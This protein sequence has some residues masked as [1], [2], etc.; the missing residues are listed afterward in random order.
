MANNQSGKKVIQYFCDECNNIINLDQEDLYNYKK[1]FFHMDCL[2]KKLKRA[3]KPKFSSEDI[4]LALEQAKKAGDITRKNEKK[5]S[6]KKSA[7]VK[8]PSISSSKNKQLEQDKNLL[9]DYI[10]SKYRIISSGDVQK[11]KRTFTSINNGTY[12]KANGIKIPYEQLYKMFVHYEQ[13]L[14]Y[15]HSRLKSP[16]ESQIL[17]FFYD[18]SVIVNKY[19]EFNQKSSYSDKNENEIKTK[20]QFEVSNYLQGRALD[21]GD[22]DD[23]LD[24]EAFLE[25][26]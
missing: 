26:Y 6:S 14:N 21:E 8:L 9:L 3:R 1:K 18:I 4:K 23:D 13:E 25:D 20:E 10:S 19:E 15:I 11:V 16:I 22:S 12:K 24:I 7:T 5:T 17:L 2:I